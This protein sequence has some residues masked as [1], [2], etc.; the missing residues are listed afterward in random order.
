MKRNRLK[1]IG[2]SRIAIAAVAALMASTGAAVAA[3]G[4]SD[5]LSKTPSKTKSADSGERRAGGPGGPGGHHGPRM[6]GGVDP[7][8]MTY[9]EMHSFKN[10]KETIQRADAGAIKAVSASSITLTERDATEVT[11]ELNGDTEFH[12]FANEDATAA[13]LKTGQRVVV[14]GEKGAPADAVMIPPKK[15]DRPPVRSRN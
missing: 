8:Y 10:G 7:K 3:G 4:S 6:I 1:Q 9:S 14:T 13:N 11:I 2:T 5:A 12:D 15:G